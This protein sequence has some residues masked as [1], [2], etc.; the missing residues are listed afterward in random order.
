MKILGLDIGETTGF[1]LID[2]KQNTVEFSEIKYEGKIDEYFYLR[3]ARAVEDELDHYQPEFVFIEGY[4]YGGGFF[5]YIVPEITGQVKRY[6][7]NHDI[8]FAFIPP[9]TLKK[10]GAGKGN[11]TKSEIKKAMKEYYL[12]NYSYEF[13][14]KTSYH[15]F[16]ASLAASV[17]ELFIKNKLTPKETAKIKEMIYENKT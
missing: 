15:I 7:F 8:K 4:A 16:D 11:A 9:N 13:M 6:L 17:G 10:I 3:T 2:I 5:N 12:T 1:C 14:K